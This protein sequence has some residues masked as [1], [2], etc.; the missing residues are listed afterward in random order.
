[1]IDLS[2]LPSFLLP[3]WQWMLR[4]PPL[5]SSG[6]LIFIEQPPSWWTYQDGAIYLRLTLHV[7]N[8]SKFPLIF[9]N[10]QIRQM[11]WLK[12]PWQDC[13]EV[14]LHGNRLT[15]GTTW[16]TLQPQTT[17]LLSILHEYNSDRPGQK[18][19]KYL[20]R[21]RDQRR[22]LHYASLTVPNR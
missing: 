10:V 20:L 1:M 7:T 19:M 2:W 3:L 11:G 9:S 13:M 21:V 22:R 15:P 5:R 12:Y 6:R 18:P 16:L 17:K 8:D 14:E 4:R